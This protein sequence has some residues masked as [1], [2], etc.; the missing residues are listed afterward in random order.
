MPALGLVVV[1]APELFRRCITTGVNMAKAQKKASA[2]D[3]QRISNENKDTG[4]KP[5]KTEQIIKLLQRKNGVSISDLQKATGWQAHS[6][7][8]FLANLRKRGHKVDRLKADGQKS[9]YC[10]AGA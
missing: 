7:H 9:T 10:I 5:S 2:T 3:A 4:K 6:V 8:G 1:Q